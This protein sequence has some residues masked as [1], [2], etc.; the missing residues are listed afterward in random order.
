MSQNDPEEFVGT[1]QVM[2][3]DPVNVHGAS[4]D[5]PEPEMVSIL[6]SED[7]EI[8]GEMVKAG[9]WVKVPAKP[10]SKAHPKFAKV[11]PAKR[12]DEAAAVL[13]S[14]NA[15]LLMARGALRVEEMAENDALIAFLATMPKVDQLELHKSTIVKDQAA[16]Q[17]R[18]DAGLPINEPKKPTHGRSPVDQAAAQRPRATAQMAST[19][20]RSNVARRVV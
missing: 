6:L 14:A 4:H 16:R 9:V 11:A 8:D 5:A 17:A 13:N 18:V 2:K 10:K 3:A 19:P 12:L 20:L 7:T 1:D 15:E